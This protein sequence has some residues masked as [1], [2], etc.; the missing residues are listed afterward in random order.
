MISSDKNFIIL[1]DAFPDL[2][3]RIKFLWGYIECRTLLESLMNDTRDGHRAG[4]PQ[5]I[6]EA[7]IAL[8]LKHDDDF[9]KFVPTGSNVWSVN[10]TWSQQ[11]E[12]LEWQQKLKR[13]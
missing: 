13:K 9:P 5:P 1:N 8:S 12:K 10:E 7:I 6:S 11:Q 4:F 3:R 2:G